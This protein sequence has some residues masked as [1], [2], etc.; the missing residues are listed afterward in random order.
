MSSKMRTKLI[1]AKAGKVYTAPAAF[2]LEI[3]SGVIDKANTIGGM[4]AENTSKRAIY[5]DAFSN[6]STK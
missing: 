6:G 1:L 4:Y 2:R 5:A 3:R